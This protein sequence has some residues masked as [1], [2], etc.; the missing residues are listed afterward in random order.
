MVKIQG[1]QSQFSNDGRVE[2]VGEGDVGLDA[3]RGG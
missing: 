3:W 1:G 2:F